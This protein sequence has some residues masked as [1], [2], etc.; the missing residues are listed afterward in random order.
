[1]KASPSNA[2]VAY[3]GQG[4]QDHLLMHDIKVC[5]ASGRVAAAAAYAMSCS[6]LLQLQYMHRIRQYY[7][8]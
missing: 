8:L 6:R 7:C 4:I 5:C 2:P 3:P 1:M